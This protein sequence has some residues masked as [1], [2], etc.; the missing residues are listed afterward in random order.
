MPREERAPL[1]L[2]VKESSTEVLAAA[3]PAAAAPVTSAVSTSASVV[4]RAAT[5]RRGA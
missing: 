1:S 4:S 5:T 2:A 3:G